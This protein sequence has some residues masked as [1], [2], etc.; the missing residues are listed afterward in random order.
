MEKRSDRGLGPWPL[1]GAAAAVGEPQQG[2]EG[3]VVWRSV[4]ARDHAFLLKGPTPVRVG[5]AAL[6]GRAS[7][8]APGLGRGVQ[9][10]QG[11]ELRQVAFVDFVSILRVGREAGKR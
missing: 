2:G 6:V 7:P 3:A 9:R 11:R 5:R 4:P 1:L 10:R 8:L